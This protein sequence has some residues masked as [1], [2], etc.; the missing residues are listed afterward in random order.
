MKMPWLTACANSALK[1][2]QQHPLNVYDEDGTLIG[3]YYADLVVDDRLIIELKAVREFA[4]EHVAQI[5]GY[6]KSSRLEHGLLVNFGSHKFQVKKYILNDQGP[7]NAL[8]N[9]T[10]LLAFALTPFLFWR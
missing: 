2:E 4:D 9:L 3:E 5:L 8:K 1:A 10:N 7:G 6:L